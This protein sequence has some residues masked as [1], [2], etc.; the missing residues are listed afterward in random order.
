MKVDAP[1]PFIQ[2]DGYTWTRKNTKI[3]KAEDEKEKTG[4]VKSLKDS[5]TNWSYQE[6]RKWTTD[7]AKARHGD[8]VFGKDK[9]AKIWW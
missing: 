4:I 5:K 9:R 8:N 2:M 7:M 1:S 6:R 3:E